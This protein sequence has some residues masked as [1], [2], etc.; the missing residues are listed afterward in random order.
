MNIE[1]VSNNIKKEN[2]KKINLLEIYFMSSE[3]ILCLVKTNSF[4]MSC[5]THFLF[6]I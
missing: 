6:V 2:N 4:F 3:L 1:L 5:E